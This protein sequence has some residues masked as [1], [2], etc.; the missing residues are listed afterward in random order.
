MHWYG[1]R[2]TGSVAPAAD[3][4]ADR[5]TERT[6]DRPPLLDGW[7]LAIVALGA[8]QPLANFLNANARRLVW[9]GP[10]IVDTVAW[11][12]FLLAVRTGCVVAARATTEPRPPAAATVP[13]RPEG[14][15]H[16]RRPGP[17]SSATSR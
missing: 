16:P 8:L 7:S 6:P 11:V 5:P 15:E 10:V 9:T 12:L 1:H 17:S 2:V 13:A 3:T 14:P 4:R